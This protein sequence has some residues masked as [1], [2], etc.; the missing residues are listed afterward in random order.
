MTPMKYLDRKLIL[1]RGFPNLTPSI[2]EQA[3]G[4]QIGR[5]FSLG[6]LLKIRE[7]AQIF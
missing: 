3:Q 1:C 7:G 4:D 2:G 6:S 5:L